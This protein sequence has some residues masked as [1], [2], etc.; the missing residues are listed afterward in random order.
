[1]IKF[2]FIQPECSVI[3]YNLSTNGFESKFLQTAVISWRIFAFISVLQK[4]EFG[5]LVLHGELF[6]LPLNGAK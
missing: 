2:I 4:E 3:P 1:M 5:V 6:F